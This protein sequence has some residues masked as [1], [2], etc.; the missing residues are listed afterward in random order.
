MTKRVDRAKRLR[1]DA[2]DAPENVGRHMNEAADH[3]KNLEAFLRD[4]MDPRKTW[5]DALV[6]EFD[7]RAR[8]LV[9]DE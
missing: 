4:L 8:E 3:I 2:V 6:A 7:K 1:D 5:T 9:G